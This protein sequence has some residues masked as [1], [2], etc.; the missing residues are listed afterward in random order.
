MLI[1]WPTEALVYEG[2]LDLFRAV[3]TVRSPYSL[4][5][6]TTDY[7]GRIWRGQVRIA[8]VGDKVPGHQ[9]GYVI[10]AFL[11]DLG[12][13]GNW[14]ELPTGRQPAPF[15]A[16]S[17]TSPVL[18]DGKLN[19]TMTEAALEEAATGQLCRIGL[20]T[21][22]VRAVS[23]AALSLLPDVLP[24]TIRA[25]TGTKTVRARIAPESQ[26]AAA[27]DATW[28]GPWLVSWNEYLRG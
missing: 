23:G 15:A 17:F 21:Y 18:Q 12:H 7:G 25:A 24:G 19:V 13:P 8:R 5:E 16:T 22:M 27:R 20:R 28:M 3:D 4:A 2:E 1:E 9:A 26:V 11:A 6:Q 14:T 10:D